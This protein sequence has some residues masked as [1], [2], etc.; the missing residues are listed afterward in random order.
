MLNGPV[1]NIPSEERFID[2]MDKFQEYIKN[3]AFNKNKNSFFL[4]KIYNTIID[5]YNDVEAEIFDEIPVMKEKINI[6]ELFEQALQNS[7][8]R[9]SEEN[10]DGAAAMSIEK[11][12]NTI[13][14][15]KKE[16]KEWN[17]LIDYIC[18]L[19]SEKY[20]DSDKLLLTN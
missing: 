8:A 16:S 4:L 14:K 20:L 15:F 9:D 18:S 3:L 11:L 6:Y 13:K 12:N 19:E 5:F 17:D 7:Y 1:Y 10:P 2:Q